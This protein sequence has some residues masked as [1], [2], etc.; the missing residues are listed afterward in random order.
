VS[1]TLNEPESQAML[2]VVPD[3]LFLTD[4]EGRVKSVNRAPGGI[5]FH[6]LVGQAFVDLISQAERPLV[7]DIFNRVLEGGPMAEMEV[8]WAE[9]GRWY[10]MHLAAVRHRGKLEGLAIHLLYVDETKR[11]EADCAILRAKLR[12]RSGIQRTNLVPGDVQRRLN[13]MADTVPM[14]IAYIDNTRCYQYN[15]AAYER[16]FGRSRE[17]LR[18]RTME[19]VLGQTAYEQI[20][21][22]VDTVL[23]GR[24]V[25]FEMI[26]PYK[27]AGSRRVIAHYVPDIHSDGSVAGFYALVEDVTSQREAEVA[28]RKKEDE[29]RQLQ[30]M[31]ALGRLAGGVAHE[32]NNLLQVITCSC[33]TIL[34]SVEQGSTLAQQTD[35]VNRAAQRGISL[36]RQLLSFSRQNEPKVIRFEFDALVNDIGILLEPLLGSGIRLAVHTGCGEEVEA[37]I[38]QIQQILMN[39][40]INARDAMPKGGLLQLV[41]DC[42]DIKKG[43]TERHV[44][45]EPGHYVRLKV[46]DTGAGMDEATRAKIFD[47]FFT[48]KPSGQGTGLGLSTVYGIMQQLRG[49]IDVDSKQGSGTAFRLYFPSALQR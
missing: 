7:E 49:H 5:S 16:W 30:K 19:D 10:D 21:T 11:I 13:L 18:E 40:A 48:T 1:I 24:A 9:T 14:L 37:D 32:F 47:P 46:A 39:L 43:E 28:L 42:V 17:E 36:T 23:A 2:E 33:S 12:D 26:V 3:H 38:S 4:Q 41:T 20:R 35:R 25:T 29:L 45:L 34:H 31:E 15:N 8:Q 44:A 22:Y 27:G 6:K